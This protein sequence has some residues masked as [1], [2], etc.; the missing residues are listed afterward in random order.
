MPA[1]AYDVENPNEESTCESGSM[2]AILTID[3]LKNRMM[4]I[5][6]KT[7]ATMLNTRA[8][9]FLGLLSVSPIILCLLIIFVIYL[10]LIPKII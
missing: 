3:E 1:I 4:P 10:P 5:P 6:K 7:I 2:F 9:I 8:T